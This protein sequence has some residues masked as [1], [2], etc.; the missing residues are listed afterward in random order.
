MPSVTRKTVKDRGARR[1]ELLVTLVDALEREL[2]GGRAYMDISVAQLIAGAGISRS[3]FYGYFNDKSDVVRLWFAQTRA[4]LHD[5]SE[6]WWELGPGVRLPDVR[7]ALAELFRTYQPVSHLMAAVYDAAAYDSAVRDEV[8]ALMEENITGLR[9]HIQA[10]QRGGWVDSA[11]APLET[12][13][14]LIWMGERTN[15]QIVL[16]T[17]LD[18]AELDRHLDAFAR[19]VWRTLYAPVAH[20]PPTAGTP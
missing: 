16:G 9:R 5:A 18:A 3:T 15:N 4:A 8:Q 7:A 2:S 19:I 17:D 11:L 1:A 13:S 10:G 12:A 6:M 14:W 20:R